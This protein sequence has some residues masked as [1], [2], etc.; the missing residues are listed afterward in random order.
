MRHGRIVFRG[1]FFEYFFMCLLLVVLSILTLGLF[2][3]YLIYW[4]FKYFF[5]NMTIEMYD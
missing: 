1:N 4:S 2:T 5:A 3:P